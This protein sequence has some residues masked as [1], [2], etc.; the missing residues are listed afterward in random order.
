MNSISQKITI[1]G[2]GNVSSIKYLVLYS[3]SQYSSSYGL[4]VQNLSLYRISSET[5]NTMQFTN[6]IYYSS[7]GSLVLDEYTEEADFKIENSNRNF[8]I[9]IDF[10]NKESSNGKLYFGTNSSYEYE[11]FYT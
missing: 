10:S 7:T 4:I 3:K 9:T 1:S 6:V 11:L 8:D 2:V 5:S